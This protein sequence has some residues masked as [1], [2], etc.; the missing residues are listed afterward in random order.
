MAH[1]VKRFE[2][3]ALM[4]AAA[5][6]AMRAAAMDL[7]AAVAA[8][9]VDSLT[10]PAALNVQTV[11]PDEA[12]AVPAVLDGAVAAVRALAMAVV[13][14]AEAAVVAAQGESGPGVQT[15][16]VLSAAAAAAV[17]VIATVMTAAAAVLKVRAWF[18]FA[19][20][21]PLAMSADVPPA[22]AAAGLAVMHAAMAAGTA[23]ADHA[24][25]LAS[26]AGLSRPGSPSSD[27]H[28]TGHLEGDAGSEC[29]LACHLKAATAPA[30]RMPHFH[31]AAPTRAT[32]QDR[33]DP[34]HCSSRPGSCCIAPKAH[35]GAAPGMKPLPP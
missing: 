13:M 18:L 9:D 29:H 34:A 17:A 31:A 24:G 3:V 32:H 30:A 6:T 28:P 19:A 21:P 27:A 20:A 4:S 1:V 26:C 11:M 15:G 8:A 5:V 14:A 2:V 22:R 35:A 10:V 7:I 25:P 12:L 33:S 16:S 23:A